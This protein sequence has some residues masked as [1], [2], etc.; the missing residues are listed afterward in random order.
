MTTADLS[1]LIDLAVNQSE[2]E[3]N[4]ARPW[5][6]EDDAFLKENL[7]Y[8][9]DAEIGKALGRTA[10]AVHLHWSRDLQL[11]SPSK[12]PGVLTA[13]D[14]ARILNLDGHKIAHWVDKGF[15]CGREM[16]GGRKIRLI[17]QED[18][19]TW[20]LNT[21]HWMYFDIQQ[22]EDADL[23]KK[24]MEKAEEWGDEWWPTSQVARYHNVKTGDVKRYIKM[25]RLKATQIK[26]SYGGRH[27]RLSWKYWFVLKS[28]AVKVK[29]VKRGPRKKKT[30]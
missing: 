2:S 17:E 12:A 6:P 18:F 16:A 26:Y 19:E 4:K 3:R 13:R 22:V 24:L 20:A 7:G 23:K 10:I 25:G 9:T 30:S 28:E 8:L 11:P 15:I 14:A 1:L 21:D 29:F 27:P 5:S